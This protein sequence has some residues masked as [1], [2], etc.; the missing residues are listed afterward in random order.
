MD[1]RYA[2]CQE[3]WFSGQICGTYNKIVRQCLL[4]YKHLF[5]KTICKII[6]QYGKE[7]GGNGSDVVI[8]HPFCDFKLLWAASYAK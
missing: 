6:V 7:L 3:C 4:L 8:Y 1:E 5:R 2:V